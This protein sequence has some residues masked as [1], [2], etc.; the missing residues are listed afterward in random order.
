MHEH[1]ERALKLVFAFASYAELGSVCFVTGASGAGKTTLLK[2]LADELYGDSIPK[3]R[4]PLIHLNANNSQQGK[5]SQKKLIFDI[6]SALGD[7]FRS[8]P[9]EIL[10]KDVLASAN[11]EIDDVAEWRWTSIVER[12]AT[13]YGLEVLIID[14]GQLMCLAPG[15]HL[16]SDYLDALRVLALNAHIRIIIAGTYDLL[17]VWNHSQHINRRSLTVHINRYGK[18][19]P[20]KVSFLG[21][22]Q[23]IEEQCELPIG[24]LTTQAAKLYQWSFGVPG[25]VYSHVDRARIYWKASDAKAIAWDHFEDSKYLPPQLLLLEQE[26]IVGEAILFSLDP[27]LPSEPPQQQ[28]AAS[29]RRGARARKPARSPVGA[30]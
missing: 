11:D 7:P 4:I 23:G 22:L 6:Y 30:T 13:A 15:R 18:S 5:F 26:I 8:D 10:P 24:M 14:E 16:P 17:E 21:V 3:D 19:R 9:A 28:K 12:L 25:E 2:M 27:T 20:Q 1:F 29:R